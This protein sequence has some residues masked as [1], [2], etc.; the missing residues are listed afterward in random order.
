VRRPCDEP[1]IESGGVPTEKSIRTGRLN[2]EEQG[3]LT[4]RGGRTATERRRRA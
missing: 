2:V 1:R 3:V 4:G